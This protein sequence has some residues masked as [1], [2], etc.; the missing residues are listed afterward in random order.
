WFD[1]ALFCV[2]LQAEPGFHS[3]HSLAAGL[4][5]FVDHEHVA[6]LAGGKQRAA[7]SKPVDLALYPELPAFAPEFGGIK[8]DADDGPVQAVAAALEHGVEC[9]GDGTRLRHQN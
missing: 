9:L 8:R 2:R 4:H 7:K 6:A 3:R 5:L 1:L